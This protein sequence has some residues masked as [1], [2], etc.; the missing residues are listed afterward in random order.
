MYYGKNNPKHQYF[1]YKD[2]ETHEISECTEEKDLGVIFDDTLKFDKH[3]NAAVKKANSMLGLI[4]R[5]FKY[6]DEDIFLKLY[7]ALVRP[8]LEY[9]QTIWYPQL[10]RQS[11]SLEKVQRRATKL[12]P[13]LENK[14]YQDRLRFLGLP[15]LK[16][17]RI[18]GRGDMIQ[19]YK[20][21]SEDKQ[22]YEHLLPLNKSRYGTK[23]H[24]LKLKKGRYSCQLRKFSFSFRVVNTWNSLNQ[25]TV[26]ANNINNFKKLLDENL[27]KLHY[28][29]D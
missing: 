9:G 14:S 5:N 11:Q 20:F 28:E 12:V 19:V 2:N 27:L 4:K 24:D 25:L 3:I 22:G 21:L 26:N 18:T 7:K 6:I 13:G 23:G 17:R 16:Y 15:S 1:F 29:I 10:V 8:H